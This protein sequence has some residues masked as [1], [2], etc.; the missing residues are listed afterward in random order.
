M[1]TLQVREII[2][3]L[4]CKQINIIGIISLGVAIVAIL[5]FYNNLKGYMKE[6]KPLLKLLAFKLVVGLE[7]LEQVREFSPLVGGLNYGKI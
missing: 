4:H 6:H 7:F 5:G 3:V 2:C 1:Y